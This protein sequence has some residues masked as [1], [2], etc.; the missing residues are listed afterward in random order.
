MTPHDAT[1]PIE[2]IPWRNPEFR[3]DPYPLYAWLRSEHPVFRDADGVFVVTRYDDVMHFGKLPIMSIREPHAGAIGPWT[4]LLNT[5]VSQNPPQHTA[6]RRQSNRWFTPKLVKQWT[7]HTAESINSV[8]DAVAEDGRVEAHHELGVIPTHLTMC[9]V[10]QVPEDDVDPVVEA[11]DQAMVSLVSDPTPEELEQGTRAFAYLLERGQ[12]MIDAKRAEP[13]DGLLDALLAAADRGEMTERAVLETLVL[14][15][16][17]GPANPGFLVTAGVEEFARRPEVFDAYR[18]EPDARA[19]IIN[20]IVRLNPPELSFPRFPME[21]IEIRGVPIPAGAQIR[22][23]IAA[24][25]RDPEMFPDPDAFDHTRPADA[26]RNLSFGIG[27]HSC[28]GQ[29]ITRMETQVIFDSL[30]D[31]YARIELD[32]EPVYA[33]TDRALAYRSLPIRLS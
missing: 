17:S 29:V 31:R 16:G 28:A 7:Q 21:D 6:L 20:E 12:A 4:A 22:F 26:S 10:L 18:A 11:M 30:A 5:V 24:A 2:R 8:L 27:P 15:W 19:A 9:R 13:G 33:F 23:M 14:F 32:G 1:V 3:A 25:N